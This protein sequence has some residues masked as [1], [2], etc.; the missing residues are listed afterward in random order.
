V[1][2]RVVEPVSGLPLDQFFAERIFAPLSMSDSGFALPRDRGRLVRVHRRSGRGFR[3]LPLEQQDHPVRGGGGLYATAGDYLRFLQCLLRAGEF[4]D[5]RILSSAA[6]AEITGNQIGGLEARMQRTA[7]ADRSNDFIFMDGTQ[8]F[9]F[10]V[11][12][13][14]RAK[15]GGRAAGTFSWAGIFNTYFWADPKND[16]AAVLMLQIAPFASRASVALLQEFEEAV[17]RDLA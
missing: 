8:K 10:G 16:L 9:G 6:V 13:E 2:G 15:P 4:G 12:I 1:V 14:T 11:M 3:Q 5:R 7:L 17:Y